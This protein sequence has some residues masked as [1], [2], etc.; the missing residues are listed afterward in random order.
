VRERISHQ[1][2]AEFVVNA[3]H[4]DG[5]QRQNKEAESDNGEEEND[6]GEQFTL[7]ETGKALLHTMEKSLAGA[8]NDESDDAGY[9]RQSGGKCEEG[10]RA[11]MCWVN[12]CGHALGNCTLPSGESQRANRK[13]ADAHPY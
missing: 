4:W 7:G 3:G 9:D 13:S 5:K 12:E 6:Y 8:G 11:E 1:E 2:V 10:R